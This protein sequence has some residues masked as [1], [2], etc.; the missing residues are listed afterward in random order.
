MSVI[1]IIVAAGSGSRFGGDMPKQFLPLCGKPVLLHTIEAFRHA[2][3]DAHI[4]VVLSPDMMEFWQGL[5]AANGAESPQIV[6]GGATRWESVK[7]AVNAISTDDGDSVVLIHDGARPLVPAE[8]ILRTI[9]ASQTSDGAIPVVPVTD[10]LREYS[11]DHTTSQPVDR[12]NYCAVQT[13]QAFPIAKLRKAF[14]HPYSH[15]FTDDASVMAAAGMTDI[16]LVEGSKHNIKITTPIDMRLAEA[17]ITDK[18]K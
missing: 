7:N 8:V 9:E 12:A 3:P 6:T 17:I 1:V 11:P 18:N 10:S 2:V 13:P 16:A 15:E 5:C 14:T 4:I